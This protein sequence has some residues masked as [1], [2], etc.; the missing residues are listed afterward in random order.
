M[1]HAWIVGSLNSAYRTVF[2][3][4]Q[5]EKLSEEMALLK[6]RWGTIDEVDMG[7]IAIA[8]VGPPGVTLP[9]NDEEG[10]TAKGVAVPGSV[11]KLA[12]N[13]PVALPGNGT[14]E[15]AA[16]VVRPRNVEEGRAAG[17]VFLGEGEKGAGESNP[18]G[19][20][21]RKWEE[22][23]PKQERAKRGTTGTEKVAAAALEPGLALPGKRARK[24][25]KR[26]GEY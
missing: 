2:E 26:L 8:P 20:G 13:G 6:L 10:A 3:I 14:G 15:L 21:K 11:E 9:G 4:L 25:P 22:I 18:S 7:G 5:A 12:V 17:V 24:A 23:K 16:G 1:H 19:K